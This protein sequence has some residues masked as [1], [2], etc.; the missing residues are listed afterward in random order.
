VVR[1]VIWTLTTWWRGVAQAP[2]ESPFAVLKCLPPLPGHV[3]SLTPHAGPPGPPSM[4][5]RGGEQPP[6]QAMRLDQAFGG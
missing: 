2:A 4:L 3:V 5:V 6:A 1:L